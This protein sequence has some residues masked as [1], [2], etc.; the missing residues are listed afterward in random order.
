LTQEL[1]GLLKSK[2]SKSVAERDLVLVQ[3][4][5]I[6]RTHTIDGNV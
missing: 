5:K 3:A 1:L 6:N 4:E 2:T